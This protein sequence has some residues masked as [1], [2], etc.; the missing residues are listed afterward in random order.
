MSGAVTRI[1][2]N[3]SKTWSSFGNL[4]RK[5][6]EY[7]IV[8][9]NMNHTYRNDGGEPLE[10]SPMAPGNVWLKTHRDPKLFGITAW[11]DFRDPDEMT[12]RKYCQLQDEQETYVDEVVRGFTVTK[13]SDQALSED[14]LSFAQNVMAPCRYLHHGM[15]MLSAY[16]QQLAPSSYV[17]NCAT[18]QTADM[19]RRVQRIAYRTK[20]LAN[21]Y[22]NR[23]FCTGE[24]AIWEGD[25]GWQP[26][27][28]AI[29]ELL[30]VYDFDRAF[31]AYEICARPVLDIVLLQQS[32]IL[33]RSLGNDGDALIAENL[34][35]DTV[36]ANRWVA[37][38]TRF[39]TAQAP[40]G[41]DQLVRS[42]A[43]F[44]PLVDTIV[45]AGAAL[46]ARYATAATGTAL[47]LR[48]AKSLFGKE[49][50][51]APEIARIFAERARAD[52]KA[53][54]AEAGL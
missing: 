32:A 52:W 42:V 24:R 6:S 15:Q 47:G 19:L 35:V 50:V 44:E 2:R 17:A 48:E 21:A 30:I 38:V 53:F 51:P 18:F 8:T 1:G 14:A 22:P 4:G 28:K 3:R 23:G 54:I 20:Q 7:E 31:V 27:R 26:I 39:I 46:L 45:E 41:K 16:I 12:Y 29:E 5:P 10:M 34:F 37:A 13:K 49:K 25:A 33:S 11:N 36:R 40:D 9:H 43:E